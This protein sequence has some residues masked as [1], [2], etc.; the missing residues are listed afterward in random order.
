MKTESEALPMKETA[1]QDFRLGVFASYSGHH[2]ASGGR[3]H[4][5]RQVIRQKVVDGECLIGPS[6]R[7]FQDVEA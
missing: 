7:T 2:P 5:V 3:V 6:L 1:E 4:N